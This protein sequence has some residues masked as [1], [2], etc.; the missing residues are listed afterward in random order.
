[1]D[2]VFPNLLPDELLAGYRGRF[3]AFNGLTS[4]AEVGAA[5]RHIYPD[6]AVR[7]DKR[8]TFIR[9]AATANGITPEVLLQRHSCFPV[10]KSLKGAPAK[11][12]T[13]DRVQSGVWLTALNAPGKMVR[14]CQQCRKHDILSKPF[15]YWRRSHQVPGRFV[16]SQHG[17]PL[18]W[19]METD[20]LPVGP[21]AT[22]TPRY[23]FDR[24]THEEI[25]QNSF[26]SRAI[27]ILD[28]LLREGLA[29]NRTSSADALKRRLCVDSKTL[30]RIP[31]ESLITQLGEKFGSQWLS[32]AMPGF[33]MNRK[34][35][36]GL[37]A[38]CIYGDASVSHMNI[39]IAATL[40]FPTAEE[41]LS[42]M[43]A[44][45]DSGR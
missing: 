18:S 36:Y 5:I 31:V 42:A 34:N 9:A 39:A 40:A 14:A 7:G 22:I 17:C 19:V 3:A 13:N 4:S 25:V 6:D 27:A 44:M 32:F 24:A 29:L 33:V 45:A 21:L 20:L 30:E 1:L 38:R 16:C 41:A 11:D 37:V 12:L 15:A 2:F 43:G 23:P 35:L 26:I 8:L 28:L 10:L